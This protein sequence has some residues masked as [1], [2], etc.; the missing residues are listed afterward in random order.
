MF[1]RQDIFHAAADWQPVFREVGLDAEA[2]FIHPHIKCWRKLDD[3]ENCTMDA[4][5]VDGR[6][7]RLHVKRYTTADPM[8][9]EVSGFRLLQEQA[10][11]TANL[12]AWG[13]L[14]DG[15]SFV[16][17]EDLAGYGA[18]D[19]LIER[20]E[21]FERLLASI[22]DLAA[23]LHRAGLH[24]RDLYLCHF[25]ADLSHDPPAV[26]LIDVARVRRL[27]RFFA[28]RWI[29]K[30]LAQLW[31]STLSLAATDEQRTR[32]MA[33]YSATRGIEFDARLRRAIERKARWIARH[34]RKLR[35]AQPKRN[36][37]IPQTEVP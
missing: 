33:R 22:A 25:F 27:P 6:K 3:R 11:P 32:L 8:H 30:D 16:I 19:K 20:G 37:S 7:I 10:I 4:E 36:I 34:D 15:R 29:V 21:S 13:H 12:V 5:L 1:E 17:T 14:A 28:R 9:A 23:K 18:A 31:Y 35:R 24:H 26:R 2:V